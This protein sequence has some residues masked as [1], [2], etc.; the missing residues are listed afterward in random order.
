MIADQRRFDMSVPSN[1]LSGKPFPSSEGRGHEPNPPAPLVQQLQGNELRFVAEKA[2]EILANNGL[3]I[4][5]VLTSSQFKSELAKDLSEEVFIRKIL[6]SPQFESELAKDLS[7]EVFIKQMI[8]SDQ[9]KSEL[10]KDL[11]EEKWRWVGL[12]LVL[13]IVSLLIMGGVYW[14]SLLTRGTDLVKI[15]ALGDFCI[16]I[17]VVNVV[18]GIVAFRA[19]K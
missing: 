4:R 10:A 17:L 9:F 11:N 19:L 6:A 18:F 8:T 3:F 1:Q 14:L 16:V 13:A 2:A 12:G 5:K 15:F 7:E